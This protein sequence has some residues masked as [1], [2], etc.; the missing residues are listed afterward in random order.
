L[1]SRDFLQEDFN[2]GLYG[3]NLS[4]DVIKIL[5]HVKMVRRGF[6]YVVKARAVNGVAC[7]NLLQ[8][9]RYSLSSPAFF[10]ALQIF[11]PEI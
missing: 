10:G 6:G 4:D 1:W 8:W 7:N 5:G 9:P 3:A 11:W 2:P